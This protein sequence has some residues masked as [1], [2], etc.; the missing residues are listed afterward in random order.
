MTADE[1]TVLWVTGGLCALFTVGLLYGERRHVQRVKWLFKPLASACFLVAAV[2]LGAHTHPFGLGVLVGL[3][4]STLGDVLL[5]PRGAGR[6][7]LA[8]L[9]AFLLAHVAYSAAFV[10]RGVDWI[11]V[12]VAAI[13]MTVIGVLVRRWLRPD[14]KPRLQGPVVAYIVVICSMA[15]LGFGTWWAHGNPLVPLAAGM[16]ILADVSVSIDRF[17]GGGF[18]NRIWG[19]PLYFAAQMVFAVAAAPPP[20]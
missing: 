3:G 19:V 16:F 2:M 12:L 6:A 17:K 4:L 13:P 9:G 15:C 11:G 14:V 1:V 8:G 7:F 20:P 5:I 18:G 10:I